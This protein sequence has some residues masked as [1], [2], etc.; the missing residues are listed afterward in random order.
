MTFLPFHS[1]KTIL[2]LGPLYL[3][4]I[5]FSFIGPSKYS[6]AY[7]SRIAGAKGRNFC[8]LLISFTVL[9]KS[10]K[11]LFRSTI[12][13]S[14]NSSISKSKVDVVFKLKSFSVRFRFWTSF[15]FLIIRAE[16]SLTIIFRLLT[17]LVI[18]LLTSVISFSY[19]IYLAKSIYIRFAL[20]PP[21]LTLFPRDR[22][23]SI[24]NKLV[25]RDQFP[26]PICHSLYKDKKHLASRDNFR[27]TKRS[28]SPS[29]TVLYHLTNI[30]V[31]E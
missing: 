17:L 18:V 3:P 29:L 31:T 24:R 4:T 6:S 26:W 8:R 5:L 19:P 22:N 30:Q 23:G 7:S 20:I 2:T 28:L 9:F 21:C 25:L 14:A 10:S 11:V 27:V 16:F 15:S 1:W 13:F 12:L